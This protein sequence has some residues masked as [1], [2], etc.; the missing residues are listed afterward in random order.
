MED[1]TTSVDQV[2]DTILETA[3]RIAN[4]MYVELQ[5]VGYINYAPGERFNVER[6]AARGGMV[7]GQVFR[8]DR[9]RSEKSGLCLS[10]DESIVQGRTEEEIIELH[11]IGK[12]AIIEAITR[13]HPD[14]FAGLIVGEARQGRNYFDRKKFQQQRLF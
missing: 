9:G 13:W 1:T 8:P 6:R 12:A 2:H 14:L 11:E 3:A 4:R 5:D 7:S 10:L